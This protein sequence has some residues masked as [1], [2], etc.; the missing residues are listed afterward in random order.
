MWIFY[1]AYQGYFVG[2]L[3]SNHVNLFVAFP[4]VRQE[5]GSF[6][7]AFF[8]ALIRYLQHRV[9]VWNSEHACTKQVYNSPKERKEGEIL[10]KVETRMRIGEDVCGKEGEE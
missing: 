5:A 6:I 10:S 9:S 8:G 2:F 1:E 7:D 4:W 3:N